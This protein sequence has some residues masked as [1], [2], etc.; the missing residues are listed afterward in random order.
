M[1]RRNLG[2]IGERQQI[3]ARPNKECV[4][5]HQNY[6]HGYDVAQV[7]NRLCWE[8]HEVANLLNVKLNGIVVPANKYASRVP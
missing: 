7:I 5:H 4:E 6:Q 3:V 2:P 8:Q 1:G